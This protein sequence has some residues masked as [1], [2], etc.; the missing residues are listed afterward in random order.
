MTEEISVILKIRLE[1]VNIHANNMTSRIPD[2][3][4]TLK[5]RKK[6]RGL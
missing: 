3:R 5:E 2:Y 6:R 1:A 4:R